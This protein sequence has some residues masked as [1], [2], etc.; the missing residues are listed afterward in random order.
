M[1]CI[2]DVTVVIFIVDV[3]GESTAEYIEAQDNG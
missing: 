3:K 1:L 2:S